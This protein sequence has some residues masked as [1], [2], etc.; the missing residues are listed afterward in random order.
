MFAFFSLSVPSASE[1]AVSVFFSFGSTTFLSFLPN[2]PKKEERRLSLVGVV[3]VTGAVVSATTGSVV[4]AGFSTSFAAFSS[5]FSSFF[6][7]LVS[8]FSSFL[9]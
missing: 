8:F 4:L 6:S 7:S 9:A 2:V 3:S 5:A 1:T